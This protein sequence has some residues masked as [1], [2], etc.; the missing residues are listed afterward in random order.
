MELAANPLPLDDSSSSFDP[1]ADSPAAPPTPAEQ[2]WEA[3]CS[4][5][6]KYF[7]APD[8]EA[9]EIVLAACAAHFHKGSDPAWLLV[10]GP[11]GGDKTSV[12]INSLLEISSVH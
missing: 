5:V 7:Y 12:I 11:S 8:L 3:Y 10:L 9:M 1:P 2:A 6:R 4:H